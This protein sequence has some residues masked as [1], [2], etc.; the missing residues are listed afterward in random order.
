MATTSQ[1]KRALEARSLTVDI[2]RVEQAIPDCISETAQT[3]PEQHHKATISPRKGNIYKEV[4]L[5]AALVQVDD[6]CY[7]A[8]ADL[9]SLQI[10][11]DGLTGL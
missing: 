8:P 10:I 4:L 5:A 6:L 7:F 11:I 1:P 3:I 2:K 9:S